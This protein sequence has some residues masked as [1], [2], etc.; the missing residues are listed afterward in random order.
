MEITIRL[1]RPALI[2]FLILA[3]AL[4]LTSSQAVAQT[5]VPPEPGSETPELMGGSPVPGGPGYVSLSHYDFVMK[6]P[7]SVTYI[8]NGISICSSNSSPSELYAPIQLPHGAR[9]NKVVVYFLDNNSTYNLNV[10]LNLHPLL[11]NEDSYPLADI[12]PA[13]TPPAYS[14][15]SAATTSINSLYATVNNAASS[16]LVYLYLPATGGTGAL[17]LSGVRIDYGYPTS[18]PLV[19][20]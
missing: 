17:C 19:V 2:V 6:Y 4:G 9:V 11:S 14:Y 12:T 1:S 7:G 15:N 13:T 20:K 10:K 16:Y 3:L 5:P 8:T 18:M